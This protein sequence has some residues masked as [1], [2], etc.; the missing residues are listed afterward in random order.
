MCIGTHWELTRGLLHIARIEAASI[1]TSTCP[2][3]EYTPLGD[4]TTPAKRSTVA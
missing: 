1:D 2:V 4:R 3:R